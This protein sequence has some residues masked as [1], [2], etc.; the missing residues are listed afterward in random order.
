[1][2]IAEVPAFL[3]KGWDVYTQFVLPVSF[4]AV[5]AVSVPAGLADGLPVGV[6]LVG[7]YRQEWALLALAEQMEAMEGFGFQTPPGFE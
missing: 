7:R 3:A 2:P 5:P 1:M 6:Q 4:A